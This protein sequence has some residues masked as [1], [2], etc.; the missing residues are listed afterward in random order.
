M[1]IMK[2]FIALIL[3]SILTLTFTACGGLFDGGGSSSGSGSKNSPADAYQKYIDMK[4]KAYD[5]ISE[6]ISNHEELAFSVGLALLPIV[7]VDL[8]LIP[9]TIIGTEG[10]AMALAFLGMEGV[11]IDQ[12]GDVYTITYSSNGESMT[13][14]CEYDKS[15]DSMKSV[16]S[17]GSGALESM[18]FEYVQSGA[19]YASQYVTLNDEGGDYTLIKMYF[20]ED[21]DVAIGIETVSGK[22]DS[23]FKKSGLT[24]DF[25]INNTSYFLL[26]GSELTIFSDGETKIY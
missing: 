14:T 4:S 12:K 20:N 23:I 6:Q 18:S 8:T 26:K 19:G 25:V 13:Q 11:N 2:K 16:I 22:P 3:A 7:M 1:K 21:G 10:G 17:G 5:R 9:L 24:S 15:S